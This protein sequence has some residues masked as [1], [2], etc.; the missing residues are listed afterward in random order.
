MS[1]K[2][3][4]VKKTLEELLEEALVPE[5]EQPYEV[6]ENWVWTRLGVIGKYYNGRAFKSSEWTDSGRPIIRIQDLTRTNNNPNY[7]EGEVDPRHEVNPG[8]L[9]IS[10][11]GTLGAYIWD[12]PQAVLNQHI[13][14]VESFINRRFHYYVVKNLINDLYN[15]THGSGMVHV[16][17]GVFENTPIPLPPIQEQKRIVDRV[18][19]LLEKI[20]EAKLLIE[21]AKETFASRR[22]AILFKAF[23]GELTEKWREENSNEV[24]AEL[25][26][27]K[28]KLEKSKTAKKKIADSVILNTGYELPYGWKWVYLSDLIESSTYGT[29]AKTSEAPSDSCIPVLRMGNIHDGEIVTDNLKYLPQDHE[30]IVRLDLEEGDLLFNRT[31]SFELVGK[32]A[33]VRPEHAGKYTFASYLVRVR[34][35]FKELL[36]EYV[37]AYIN[38]N[39]GR[40]YL[41]SQATQQVGQANINPTKLGTLPIPLP[42]EPELRVITAILKRIKTLEKQTDLALNDEIKRIQNS[43]L[44]KAF[45]GELGTNNPDEESAIELIKETLSKQLS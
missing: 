31:N 5:E 36:S 12:G 23:R 40:E 39:Q 3:S 24:T 17:K 20:N 14:K 13:F 4:K 45:R 34:L 27:E 15:R 28:I 8:D 10:W 30:D 6:P 11:S 41:L 26:I 38:S 25:L 9:L 35:V 37:C 22:A 33:V 19:S 7:F 21:E 2:N 18:E 1:K 44:Q 16:T 29:S 32:T 43:I 42:P